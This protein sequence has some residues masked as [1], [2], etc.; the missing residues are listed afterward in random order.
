LE[1]MRQTM[2]ISAIRR[3][4]PQGYKVKPLLPYAYSLQLIAG[5]K[6]LYSQNH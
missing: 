1:Q 2:G 3:G 6:P 4:V 5:A